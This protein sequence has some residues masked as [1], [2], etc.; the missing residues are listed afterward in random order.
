MIVVVEKVFT[1]EALIFGVELSDILRSFPH[2]R[3]CVD[4]RW[5]GQ[6]GAREGEISGQSGENESEDWDAIRKE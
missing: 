3:G 2:W 4:E 1:E 5:K 6:K